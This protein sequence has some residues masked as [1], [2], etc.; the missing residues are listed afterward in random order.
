MI[1][2]KHNDTIYIAASCWKFR[3]LESIINET[4]NPENICMW[5]PRKRKKQ[6]IAASRAGWFT[7]IIRYENIFPSK[8]ASKEL[9][10]ESY[11][12]MHAIADKLDICKNNCI[13][14][15]TVFAEGDRA[16]IVNADSSHLEIENIYCIS[17]EDEIVMALYNLKG[18]SD[19]Y[20]FSRR[21]IKL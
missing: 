6:I 14:I 9:I 20:S 15:D 8:L 12:K 2:L 10:L 3:D 7:D 17:A 1:I 11:D 19:P 5:H 4:P 21:H 13:P 16:Y 18:V